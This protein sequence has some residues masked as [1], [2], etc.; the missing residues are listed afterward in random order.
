M[1]ASSVGICVYRNAIPKFHWTF[2]IDWSTQ[3]IKTY[4]IHIQ[5]KKKK[6]V[7]QKKRG[8]T[9]TKYH[10]NG[11][12]EMKYIWKAGEGG[13]RVEN[14][15]FFYTNSKREKRKP[16]RKNFGLFFSTKF[17]L[18]LLKTFILEHVFASEDTLLLS[19]KKLWKFSMFSQMESGVK[20]VP[21]S[22]FLTKL[23]VFLQSQK[24]YQ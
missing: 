10:K 13:G 11:V 19:W 21:S 5:K 24:F 4:M 1:K 7:L 20:V 6:N 22:G 12:T 17:I 2:P 8:K 23:Y 15:S 14:T 3:Y 16:P 9:R 18:V